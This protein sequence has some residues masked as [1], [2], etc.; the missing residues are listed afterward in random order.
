MDV[1]KFNYILK[2]MIDNVSTTFPDSGLY[3]YKI[4][5]SMDNSDRWL[6]EFKK[7]KIRKFT[8]IET[9]IEKFGMGNIEFKDSHLEILWEY[10]DALKT[11]S[12]V[13]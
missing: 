8:D 13:A 4:M 1:Y 12:Q 6:K 10:I 2:D 11:I 5:V 7:L 9:V 3:K